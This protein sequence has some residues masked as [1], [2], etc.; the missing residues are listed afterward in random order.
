MKIGRLSVEPCVLL[1]LAAVIDV[2][3][4]GV[5]AY[6][7]SVDESIV[8]SSAIVLLCTPLAVCYS[9]RYQYEYVSFV[10]YR[11]AAGRSQGR[12]HC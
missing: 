8:D 6:P 9:Y 10:C 3:A 11:L 7:I 2:S 5:R 4:V 1:P 12:T